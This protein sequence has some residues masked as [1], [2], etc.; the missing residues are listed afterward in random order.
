MPH[1]EFLAAAVP[2]IRRGS[3][4]SKI[5][6]RDPVVTPIDLFFHFFSTSS[7][8]G[9]S[10]CQ[11]WSFQLL[12]FRDTEGVPNIQNRIT[13]PPGDPS[14]PNFHFFPLVSPWFIPHA[15]FWVCR[16]YRSRDTEGVREFQNWVMGPP[17]DP[18]W[19]KFSLFP[20]IPIWWHLH[21]KFRLSSCYLS[22]D[23]EGSQKS[24]IGSRYPLVTPVIQIFI[25]SH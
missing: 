9:P 2:E 10:A 19:P 16:C 17:R 6:S 1:F 8:W 24:K 3:Q 13:W 11:I 12:L 22:R 21:S 4:N 7:P 18:Q 23:T 5:G 25:F 14:N 15:K 20:L